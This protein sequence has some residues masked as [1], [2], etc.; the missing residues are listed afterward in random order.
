M[1][2]VIFSVSFTGPDILVA[3]VAGSHAL[4]NSRQK[5][6]IFEVMLSKAQ[7]DAGRYFDIKIVELG[8]VPGW[9]EVYLVVPG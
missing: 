2:A 5:R 9:H 8:F 3:I 4:I 7:I 1:W 6:S